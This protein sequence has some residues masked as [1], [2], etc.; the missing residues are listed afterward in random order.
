MCDFGVSPSLN[1]RAKSNPVT[2]TRW[3]QQRVTPLLGGR[4]TIRERLGVERVGSAR[5]STL[6]RLSSSS[7]SSSSPSSSSAPSTP[8][9]G[10]VEEAVKAGHALRDVIKVGRRGVCDDLVEHIQKRWNTSRVVKL[11]CSGKRANDMKT[12]ACELEER[13]GGSVLFR[14]G[15]TIIIHAPGMFF[16]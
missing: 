9:F 12:L 2:V 5:P 10:S 4:K 3:R 7:S 1:L 14:S 16:F 15:G 11:H 8:C 13:T 6:F